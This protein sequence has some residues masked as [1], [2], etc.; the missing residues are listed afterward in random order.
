MAGARADVEAAGVRGQPELGQATEGALVDGVAED[1]KPVALVD[2]GVVEDGR[3]GHAF[4]LGRWVAWRRW[5]GGHAVCQRAH[6]RAGSV[7]PIAPPGFETRP[8]VGR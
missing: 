4:S 7:G 5:P 8:A 3:V 6:A 2:G 1:G